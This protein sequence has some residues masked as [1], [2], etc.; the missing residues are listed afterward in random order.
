VSIETDEQ[1]EALKAIG[2]IVGQTLRSIARHVRPGITTGDLDAI[3]AKLLAAEGARS[4]PP[5]VYGFPGAVCI[6]VNDEIVHGVPGAYVVAAGDLVKLDLTAEKDG[7]MADAAI[8]VPV[9][10][11]SSSAPSSDEA[12]RLAQCAERAF[13]RAMRVARANHRIS[14]IGAVVETE[15]RRGGFAVVRDLCGHGIGRTIHEEPQVPNYWNPR[16]RARLT[17]GLVI[18]VEPIIAA[19]SGDAVLAADGWTMKTADRRLA[20]HFEHTIVVTKHEPILLTAA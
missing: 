11:S 16:Q 10:P 1:L 15:V 18:A 2:R 5:I 19:G 14:D 8:S 12:T 20:A 7:Y 13:E 4:A 6:S 3:G 17:D 9:P